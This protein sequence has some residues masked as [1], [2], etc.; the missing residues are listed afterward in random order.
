MSGRTSRTGIQRRRAARRTP[1]RRWGLLPLLLAAALSGCVTETTER[2]PAP[3]SVQLQAHLDLARGYLENRDY[4]RAREPL[5]RALEIDPRS[6]EAATL[7]AVLYQ[8]QNE[9][10]L[11]ERY[12]R[13]A[14][15]SDPDFSMA[16]NNYGTFLYG[17]GRFEDAL[18]PLR[19]LVED[20]DYRE[21]A[22][23]YQN[24]GLTELKV[25]NKD[26]AREAFERSLSFNAVLP[27][28]CL[29]L[30]QLAYE[31]GAFA[32]AGRY[33]DMFR[34]RARQTPRSL[35]LGIELAR[36]AG[37]HDQRAS[38]EIALKN[39]YPDSAEARRCL[40]DS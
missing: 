38:Y 35:C 20:P 30:A 33:Y 10:E 18:D 5:E 15:R 17:R 24:L 8:A 16:L 13:Q 14:L 34:E 3:R 19:R 37:N 9:P 7:M 27:A 28:S 29:E 11:A 32:D 12:Y 23:A 4:N 26:R 1:A 21:R 6:A 40:K 2:T 31:D 22:R 25:G 39:L 36:Q